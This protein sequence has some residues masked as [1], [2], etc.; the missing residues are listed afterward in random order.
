M[1]TMRLRCFAIVL[2]AVGTMGPGC[3]ASP[4]ESLES[5]LIAGGLA[6]P[7]IDSRELFEALAYDGGGTVLPGKTVKFVID[8]RRP[9]RPIFYQNANYTEPDGETPDAARYHY[10]FSKRL[11]DDFS[12]SIESFNDKTYWTNDKSYVAGT[13]QTY[14]LSGS[15]EPVFG[16]QFYP[17][18]VI[19][20][21]VLLE[22]VTRVVE[23]MTI[24]GAKRAFVATGPQQTT[25]TIATKLDGLGVANLTLDDVLGDIVYLPWNQGEAWGFLRIFPVDPEELS[26]VDIPVFEELPIDLTVVAAT[27]TK[28]FQDATSHVNLKAKERDTPNMVLRDAGPQHPELSA[29]ADKPVHLVVGV[30]DW[31]IELSTEEEVYEKLKEKTSGPWTSLP[32]EPTDTLASYAAMC[33]SSAA[34]CLSLT[35][36]YGSKASNLGFMTNRTVLGR[37]SD[38]SS[39]SHELGY[40]LVPKG[41]GVPL[42]FYHDFVSYS[43]NADLRS[44]I[45]AL[46]DAEMAGT[47]SPS[48]RR[49][50]AEQVRQAFYQASFPPGMLETIKS[51]LVDTMPGITKFKVRSSA[52]AEDMPN[53]DGAGLYNSFAAKLNEADNPDGSCVLGVDPDDGEPEMQPKTVACAVKGV[54]GSLWNKRAIEERSYARLDHGTALM[55]LS[56]VPKYDLEAPIAAN[57]VVVSR[58]INTDAVSGYTFATQV[59]NNKVTNPLPGTLAENVIA[60]FSEADVPPSFVVTR[61]ATP[62]AG[63][64]P[65]ST[66][67]MTEQQMLAMLRITQRVEYRYC[68]ARPDYYSGNCTWALI[69]PKKPHSLDFELKL[70]ENGHFSCKQVREFSGQ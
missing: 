36:R 68:Q 34:D 8:R 56:V 1:S 12:E 11:L 35:K 29:F 39:L 43:A 15:A 5:A 51:R 2:V 7:T 63:Q 16:I 14:F 21:S 52:N 40:D 64:G 37:A 22:A 58:V 54:F 53:F 4:S 59:G 9:E 26:A 13:L 31:S 33:P 61:H 66:N 10:D 55:A 32:Y 41:F 42:K 48:A 17:Q 19:N 23:T 46:V 67:V 47:L 6:A 70:L 57:S 65:L 30:E 49:A 28:A 60:A 3:V 25:T 50:K 62:V 38:N 20:E 27:M 24:P 69:D 44:Q 18:D 45:E